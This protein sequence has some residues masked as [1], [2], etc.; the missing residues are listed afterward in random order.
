MAFGHAL[1]DAVNADPDRFDR[2]SI[3]K[4]THD[5]VFDA[6]RRVLRAFK[7]QKYD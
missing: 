2:V 4:E 3:L 1:R 6:T 7:G 5:P